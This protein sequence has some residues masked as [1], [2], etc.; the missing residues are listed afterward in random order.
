M[1]NSFKQPHLSEVAE[2]PVPNSGQSRASATG[3]YDQIS[4]RERLFDLVRLAATSLWGREACLAVWDP[5][6]EAVEI[7]SPQPLSYA[8]LRRL[9]EDVRTVAEEEGLLRPDQPLQISVNGSSAQVTDDVSASRLVQTMVLP[10]SMDGQF[11]GVLI[12]G[13]FS[14]MWTESQAKLIRQ[15]A[16]DVSDALR[17]LWSLVIDERDRYRLLLNTAL[18]GF[19]LCDWH[20]QILFHNPAALQLLGLPLDGDHRATLSK[21]MDTLGLSGFINE[22]TQHGIFE[23]NKIFTTGEGRGRIIGVNVKLLRQP[24]GDEIGW[25]LTLR[26]VTATWEVDRMK[27]M[28]SVA[29][30]EIN[31][32]LASVQNAVDLLLDKEIGEI[33]EQQARCLEVVHSDVTRLRHLLHDLLD[34]SVLDRD[35]DRLDRRRF[36]KLGFVARKVVGS[37][38]WLAKER[39]IELRVEFPEDLSDVQGDRDRITQVFVNIVDNALRFTR[40]GG[41]VELRAE[42]RPEEI[43][44]SVRDTGV[45]IP[46]DDLDRIFEKF[47]QSDNLLPDVDRGYGLGLSIAREIVEGHRGRIW[48]ESEVGKG[49]TF[50][51]SFPK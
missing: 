15:K 18:E 8:D 36:V 37:F 1:R 34:L 31:T 5:A 10:V 13:A 7:H 38:E 28:L 33:N 32:P 40:P 24:G 19:I 3:T 25:L 35:E 45:G 26:D 29:S 20:K 27:S 17:L 11:A 51:F 2:E 50:Y 41:L 16:R 22:A 43:V 48:V 23:L 14:R 39:E 30:H 44:V 42:E 49:S 4:S 12:V 47:E 21:A 9:E 46:E 6:S